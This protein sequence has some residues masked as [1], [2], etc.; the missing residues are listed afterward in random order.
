MT[1]EEDKEFWADYDRAVRRH[2]RTKKI[3]NGFWILVILALVLAL[4]LGWGR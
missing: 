3:M 4:V 1:S 2:A